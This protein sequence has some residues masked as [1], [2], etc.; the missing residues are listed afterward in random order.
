MADETG[1]YA[2]GGSNVFADAGL[3]DAD[4]RL[5]RA[6]PMRRITMLIKERDLTQREVTDLTGVP[7][8]HISLL[9]RGRM[10]SFSLER[11]LHMLTALGSDVTISY[12]PSNA[13]TGRLTI[14]GDEA[15]AP[16]DASPES[17]R[18]SA[19]G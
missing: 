18:P 19:V 3:P 4:E 9:L 8:P 1:G 15:A 14:V 10:S 17:R 13:A 7:Q 16:D 2:V 12:H 6:M 5:V 11:L